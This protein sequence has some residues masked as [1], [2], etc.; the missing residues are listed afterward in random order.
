M[1]LVPR[2]L[3]CLVVVACA[4]CSQ[5]PPAAAPRDPSG[6]L[7]ALAECSAPAPAV[8]EGVEGLILPEGALVQQVTPSN[9]L[10]NIAAYVEMTPVEFEQHYRNREGIEVLIGENE[11]YEAEMLVSDGTYRNFLKATAVCARG[12]QI[13]GV[14]APEVSA[15][16]LPVP[17]G[18]PTPPAP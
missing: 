7:E 15:E 14:V 2:L 6:P 1:T 17:Q 12:V 18:S 4:A 5:A 16:G 13:I 11:I 10:T 8:T 3:A 9:P